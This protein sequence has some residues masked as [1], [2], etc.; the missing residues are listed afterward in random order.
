MLTV[1]AIAVSNP[2]PQLVTDATHFAWIGLLL[3]QIHSS[4][5]SLSL[6]DRTQLWFKNYTFRRNHLVCQLDNTLNNSNSP[7]T[8]THTH[9][10]TILMYNIATLVLVTSLLPYIDT[11]LQ[12]T[13]LK[14][15]CCLARREPITGINFHPDQT[16]TWRR[17]TYPNG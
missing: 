1:G 3:T 4:F 9:T 15:V 5:L 17:R 11:I 2:R 8:H 12:C 10:H 7:I 16:T 13:Q 14:L 6:I